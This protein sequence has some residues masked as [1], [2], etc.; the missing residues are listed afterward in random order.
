MT[1]E[2]TMKP[3]KKG[4]IYCSTWCGAGCTK[5]AHTAAVKKARKLARRL[6]KNWKP[7]VWES[8][9]WHGEAVH[10]SGQ[11]TVN[12]SHLRKGTIFYWASLGEGRWAQGA[13]TPEKAIE[14]VL[15]QCSRSLSTLKKLMASVKET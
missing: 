9:G 12:S 4:R 2:L 3:V 7:R 5:S 1:R 13:K 11:L 8:L 6:G 15:R 14:I 10:R